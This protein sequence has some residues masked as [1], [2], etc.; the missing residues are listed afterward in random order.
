MKTML[1]SLLI[2][3]APLVV[4]LARAL[5]LAKRRGEAGVIE[6]LGCFFKAPMTRNGGTP[7]HAMPEQQRRMLNWL[8]AEGVQAVGTPERIRG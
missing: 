1:R 2:L 4:E 8:N 7:E 6:E 5:D 3:A